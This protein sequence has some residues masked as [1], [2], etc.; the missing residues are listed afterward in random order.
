MNILI[1][2]SNGFI[3]KS[4]YDYFS[5][6]YNVY[7]VDVVESNQ[8]NFS[9]INLVSDLENLEGINTFNFIIN[10]SGSTDV[11]RSNELPLNDFEKNTLNVY[12]IL[13][14]IKVKN[15]EAK[16][17]NISSGAVYGNKNS[18]AIETDKLN[19]VSTYG[20]NKKITEN[21]CE[22]FYNQF[23]ISSYSLRIFSA[24][25]P[26][27]KR[28]LFWDL[29]NK[30]LKTNQIEL[31][32]DST[33][34]R[35]FI[36]IDDICEFIKIIVDKNISGYHIFNLSSGLLITI[37]SAVKSFCNILDKNLKFS[38]SGNSMQGY[39]KGV[40][41]DISKAKKFGFAPKYTLEQG[42]KKTIE[43]IEEQKQ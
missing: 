35:D 5:S 24:Y 27:L 1:I 25:G 17:I 40:F 37:E 23:K 10:A 31:Y 32:G 22:H 2:G 6:F 41:A 12:E 19:P 14:I 29:Y 34:Y 42:L 30:S 15:P 13:S 43:W 20:F 39:P 21:I 26:G 33:D 28:Q 4:L 11:K 38:F 3:G 16:F 8:K 36:Y 9:Q 7:G 18:A